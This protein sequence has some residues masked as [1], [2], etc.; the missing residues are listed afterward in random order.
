M[1]Q[2]MNMQPEGAVPGS[3]SVA[4]PVIIIDD[5][6]KLCELIRDY[7]APL[8]YDVASANTG[9]EGLEK[10]LNGNYRAVIL[11]VM[12][13]K[14]NGFDVLR[15]VSF[16]KR[17][18]VL[19]LTAKGDEV[20]R[21]LGLEMGADDYLS[22]PC[23]PRELTARIRSIIRRT[24]AVPPQLKS[25]TRAEELVLNDLVINGSRRLVYV[26]K[27]EIE[28][29]ATEFQILYL[30]AQNAGELVTR[31]SISEQCMG[32]RLM[33][34]DRSIDMHISHLRRK[35]GPDQQK[36]ERIKTIRG[37]GYQYVA[38]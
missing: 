1:S 38:I 11:D 19:M 36:Q 6:P 24:H 7:L 14:K 29:T 8:G 31:E 9:P 35:L 21:I 17:P 2:T 37:V 32:R 10:V 4:T 16:E 18:P 13:P 26:G 20:D 5:D 25:D 23:N 34:F 15:E 3:A 22:K 12:L 27:T 28:L 33:A 30:L